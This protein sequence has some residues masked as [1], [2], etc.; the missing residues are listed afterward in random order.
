MSRLLDQWQRW[1]FEPAP[2]LG[3]DQPDLVTMQRAAW[4]TTS[5]LVLAGIGVLTRPALLAA[6]LLLLVQEGLLMSFGKTDHATIPLLYALLFFALSPC[7][8]RFSVTALARR[9]LGRDL[10]PSESTF[11]RWP[12]ELLYVVLSSFYFSAGLSK[13]RVSGLRWVDGNT[14]QFHL[15][16]KQVPLGIEFAEFPWLCAVA[17]ALVLSWQIGFP[18]GLVRQLRPAFLLGGVAFHL[19]TGFLMNVWF[20]PV[21]YLYLVFVPW[22]RLATTALLRL[23]PAATAPADPR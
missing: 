12:T 21:P 9:M 7:D 13:L 16:Q 20:W 15:L 10:G 3:L 8:R 2:L 17:S 1:W 11:A 6:F 19:G 23:R 14:L 4:A 22:S 18:L 5:A